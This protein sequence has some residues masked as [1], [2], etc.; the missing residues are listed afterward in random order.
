M[1]NYGLKLVLTLMILLSAFSLCAGESNG[2]KIV[3]ASFGSFDEAKGALA[4][5][6]E[7][8]GDEEKSLQ[9][10]QK[11]EI[12]ARPSGKAFILAIEP[13][14]NDEGSKVVLKQFKKFYP[15]AYINGYFGPTQ[16]SVS[17]QFEAKP[18]VAE[19][20]TT[21]QPPIA[22]PAVENN[23]IEKIE[24]SKESV[25]VPIKEEENP[26]SSRPIIYVIILI[27]AIGASVLFARKRILS[28][29]PKCDEGKPLESGNEDFSEPIVLVKDG[30]NT[31]GED[32]STEGT[33]HM[34]TPV[35]TSKDIFYTF[36]KNIFFITLLN[37]LQ[38]A[39]QHKE[40]GRCNEIM[41]EILRYQKNFQKSEMMTSMKELLEDKELETLAAFIGSEIE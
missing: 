13:L 33:S 16:G 23:A 20:N 1:K 10:K 40:L 18:A 4:K 37:E 35:V 11:F 24:T 6:G 30:G 31:V 29:V 3:L 8:L 38:S 41:D 26:K 36:K 9:A 15:D 12:L 19:V 27:I 7:K 21:Q 22:T 34:E 14:E 5:I 32:G 25:V 2:Y 17:L 39:A 28:G